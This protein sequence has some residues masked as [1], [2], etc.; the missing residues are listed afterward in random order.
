MEE[1]S[2]SQQKKLKTKQNDVDVCR[3]CLD[4]ECSSSRLLLLL[5]LFLLNPLFVVDR[6]TTIFFRSFL[7]PSIVINKNI[8]I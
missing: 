4:D 7:L 2:S 5:L 3:D 8:F 1:I 6:T